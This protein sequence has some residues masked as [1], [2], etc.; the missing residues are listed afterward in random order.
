MEEVAADT[1]ADG[2]ADHDDQ[3]E[4]H[5]KRGECADDGAE[6]RSRDHSGNQNGR[7]LTE[8]FRVHAGERNHARA[9]CPQ[10]LL[11]TD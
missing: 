4:Q 1:G 11:R 9:H 10:I 6:G 7:I 3:N 2:Y 5:V 8:R